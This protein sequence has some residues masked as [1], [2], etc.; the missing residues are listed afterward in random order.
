MAEDSSSNDDRCVRHVR[1]GG[2]LLEREDGDG[3]RIAVLRRNRYRDRD[4]RRGD[5]ALP[6]G[7]VRGGE[8]VEQAALR[9]VE[10]ET[11]CRATIVGPAYTCEYCADGKP[12][13]ATYYR[14]RVEDSTGNPDPGEVVEVLWLAPHEA[15]ERLTYDTE[16]DIVAQAY[17]DRLAG[18]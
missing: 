8:S 6:K 13:T 14:M 15:L 18:R 2:G 5:V 4:G 3:L 17:R 1:A 12:K 10:E 16:R 9:E 7:K 11:G